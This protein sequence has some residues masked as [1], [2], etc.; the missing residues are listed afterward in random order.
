[1]TVEA[2]ASRKAV[3][4]CTDSGGPAELVGDGVRGF[5]VRADAGG[6]RRARC[7]RLMDDRTLAETLRPQRVRAGA[8]HDL[9][10]HRRRADS[11]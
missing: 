4:T 3:V 7:R 9:A 10:G 1:M 2:F 8:H 6:A 5:V 11:A